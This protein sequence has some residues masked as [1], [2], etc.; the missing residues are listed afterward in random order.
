MGISVKRLV[1]LA[2]GLLVAIMTSP[3]ALGQADQVRWDIIS[4]GFTTPLT[5]NPGG[6]S[7][8]KAPDN[9]TIRFTGAGTFVAPAGRYGGNRAVRGGGTWQTFDAAVLASFQLPNSLK[10]LPADV[11]LR[12]R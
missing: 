4:L 12:G 1:G 9:T 10:N 3:V 7:D 8:A 11:V 5:F 6:F 2:A